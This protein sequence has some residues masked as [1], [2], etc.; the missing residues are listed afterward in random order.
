MILDLGKQPIVPM[1]KYGTGHILSQK[2]SYCVL[3]IYI[4]HNHFQIWY[5]I[6]LQQMFFRKNIVFS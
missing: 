2:Y 1:R 3:A 6:N 4:T 5:Y